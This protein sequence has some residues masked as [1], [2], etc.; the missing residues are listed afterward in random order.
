MEQHGEMKIYVL[1][2][3]L[4]IDAS[5]ESKEKKVLGPS[6]T[7][8]RLATWLENVVMFKVKLSKNMENKSK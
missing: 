2:A 3:E 6:L 4:K 8:C 1:E 7:T 5:Q